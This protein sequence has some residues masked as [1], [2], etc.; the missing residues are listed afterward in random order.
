MRSFEESIAAISN[1]VDF[2][3]FDEKEVE[4][5]FLGSDSLFDDLGAVDEPMPVTA[6]GLPHPW[7]VP[8]RNSVVSDDDETSSTSSE[9]CAPSNNSFV[10]IVMILDPCTGKVTCPEQVLSYSAGN[11][12]VEKMVFGPTVL[13]ALPQEMMNLTTM[14]AT[15][16]QARGYEMVS[17]PGTP[18]REAM[19]RSS[20]VAA[21]VTPLIN[22]ALMPSTVTTAVA[23]MPPL[24]ALSAYNFYFRDERGTFRR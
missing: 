21:P 16:Q 14:A 11:G 4:D 6:S 15:Q 23:G 19:T 22:A 24:R 17:P 18:T 9:I 1:S 2:T 8:S 20:P 5:L 10:N 3:K 7:G 12:H 13:D